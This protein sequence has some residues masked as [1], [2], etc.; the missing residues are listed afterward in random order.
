MKKQVWLT[1]A[2]LLS[3][4]ACTPKEDKAKDFGKAPTKEER[5][6]TL[7]SDETI[8]RDFRHLDEN[9]DSSI[10]RDEATTNGSMQLQAR[11][12][13]FDT[14]KDG[15][16]TLQ[17]TIAYV[18]TLREEDLRRK[19]E[20]FRNIDTDHDGGISKDEAGK[21]TDSFFLDHFDEIDTNNDNKLSLFELNRYSDQQDAQA[22]EPPKPG[23]PGPLF[24]QMDK[25]HNGTLSKD[26]LKGM[27]EFYKSFDNMDADHDG[28]ITPAEIQ[29]YARTNGLEQRQ[30]AAGKA[31]PKGPKAP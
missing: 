16:L 6:Q 5:K 26:E 31:A 9:H 11:F 30:P 13:E 7:I 22:A 4:V 27:P 18:K 23:K 24:L 1:A 14:N 10:S 29:D 19:S 20:A 2:V 28:K 25:D 17:E 15:K 3:C 12:D 8:E 21:Q